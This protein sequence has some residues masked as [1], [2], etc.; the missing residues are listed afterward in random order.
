MTSSSEPTIGEPSELPVGEGVDGIEGALDGADRFCTDDDIAA[1]TDTV[2]EGAPLETDEGLG[3]VAK[4]TS[5]NAEK[6]KTLVEELQEHLAS[7]PAHGKIR[8]FTVPPEYQAVFAGATIEGTD[9]TWFVQTADWFKQTVDRYKTGMYDPSIVDQDILR[10]QAQM[11]YFAAWVNH[12]DGVAT[13]AEST[14]KR[15]QSAAYLEGRQW[16]EAQGINPRAVSSD[17]LKALADENIVDRIDY[18]TTAKVT[19]ETIKGFYFALKDFIMYLDRVSQRAQPDRLRE[20]H[21]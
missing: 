7:E 20:R 9:K 5:A 12:L 18:W 4:K 8:K 6:T 1:F 15:A 16:I 21:R 10:L 11:V 13:D 3:A 19:S 14:M 17:M 2:K